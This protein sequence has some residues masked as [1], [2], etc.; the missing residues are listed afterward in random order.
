MKGKVLGH[1]M[2]TCLHFSG[3]FA[4]RVTAPSG[5][6]A[7]GRHD[8]GEA[9]PDGAGVHG[10]GMLVSASAQPGEVKLIWSNV[11]PNKHVPTETSS[12]QSQ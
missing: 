12:F 7:A 10:Q 6:D 9:S 4:A 5:R 2:L 11:A 8:D 1:V 3:E